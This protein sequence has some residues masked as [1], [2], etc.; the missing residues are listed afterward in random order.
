MKILALFSL[1]IFNLISVPQA[2]PL[3]FDHLT[4]KD[5]LS[6]SSVTAILQDQHGLMWFGTQ[7]GLNLYD[8]VEFTIF[9]NSPFDSSSLTSTWIQ[10]LAED[11]SGNIWIGT[12]SGGIFRYTPSS[13]TFQQYEFAYQNNTPILHSRVWS[14]FTDSKDILWAGT[15]NGLNRYNPDK[16]RFELLALPGLNK[17]AVNDIRQAKDGHLWLG[18]FGEGLIEFDE[19]LTIL[20]HLR[21][22]DGLNIDLIKCISLKDSGYVWIG[23]WGDGLKRLHLSSGRVEQIYPVG[24]S[25][26]AEYIMSLL[27]DN[28]NNLWAGTRGNGLIRVHTQNGRLY[29]HRYDKQNPTSLND[30]WVPALF[31]DSSGL[32]WIGTGRGIAT[33]DYHKQYFKNIIPSQIN[34]RFEDADIINTVYFDG[35]DLWL[36]SWGGG[37]LQMSWQGKIKQVLNSRQSGWKKLSSDIVWCVARQR[38]D[39][40]WVGTANGLDQVFPEKGVSRQFRHTP[41]KTHSLIHN[42]ISEL[43]F[44]K[45]GNLWIGTWGGGLCY[46]DKDRKKFTPVTLVTDPPHRIPGNLISAIALDN[47]N[48]LWVGTAGGG[49]SLIP[50]SY[51]PQ[52]RPVIQSEDI[53]HFHYQQSNQNS[54]SSNHITSIYCSPDGTVWLGF[55]DTG[56]SR[57][58]PEENVFKH[59]FKGNGLPDHV[60]HSITSDHNGNLWLSTNHGLVCF[61]PKLEEFTSFNQSSGLASNELGSGIFIPEKQALVF[62]S[63]EGITR[64]YP[65]AIQPSPYSPKT[66]IRKIEIGSKTLRITP[67]IGVPE[68]LEIPYS[69]QRILIQYAGLNYSSPRQNR[70][71]YRLRGMFDEWRDSGNRTQTVFYGLPAGEYTFEVKC[72]NNCTGNSK[73]I[74]SVSFTVLPPFWQTTFFRLA[75]VFAGIFIFLFWHASRL[76]NI[77]RQK[78]Q[79]ENLV[80]LRTRELD[81]TN[82]ALAKINKDQAALLFER[83]KLISELK[84]ALGK[85]KTLS[86]LLPICSVCKKIRDDQGYWN[87]IERYICE[88]SNADFSHGICPDC[89]KDL[90]PELFKDKDTNKKEK[91]SS[92]LPPGSDN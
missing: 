14:L 30:N 54:I 44:D 48:R 80:E 45:Q 88:H 21:A 91:D 42:N 79:L 71:A 84:E 68:N 38:P 23:T 12:H 27:I 46:L 76:K 8:G 63:L 6:Q 9:T 73:S 35:K 66:V 85:V 33:M 37:L 50:L 83:E 58:D 53:K 24:S 90:Y 5:G 75:L 77:T 69:G 15:A 81:Q 3:Q 39:E 62:S 26:P 78:R 70:Y 20:K 11:R 52:G 31:Q 7:S 47:R 86:G 41:E 13:N 40:L 59:Y 18:T 57:Y 36:G 2:L 43:L 17:V 74:A 67:G 19:K 61:N 22:G 64:F 16:D 60:V 25:R 10:C 32:I 34:E 1:L 29:R 56:F 89:A 51:S 49:L 82:K 55:N 65:N 92:D 28:R 4:I 72:A 87:N